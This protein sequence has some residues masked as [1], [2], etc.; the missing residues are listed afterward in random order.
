[1]AGAEGVVS[2]NGASPTNLDLPD[3]PGLERVVLND[4]P[5]DDQA[6]VM[7]LEPSERSRALAVYELGDRME[8]IRD[9]GLIASGK[10]RTKAEMARFRLA[11]HRVVEEHGP[12]TVRGAFYQMVARGLPKTESD[13]G[14]V[15]DEL[16]KM[17]RAERLPVVP[18]GWIVD[19]T[20]WQRKPQTYSSLDRMLRESIQT[21]RRAVWDDQDVYCEVWC[22]KDAL[23]G[24]LLPVTSEWD[25]PLMVSRG[26]SSVTFLYEAAEAIVAQDKPAF[27]YLFTDHDRSGRLIA[28][29][30]EE[31]LTGFAPG[32]EIHCVRA[33]V[34]EEQIEELDLPTRPA[35]RTGDPPAVELDAIRPADLR[36][37][38]R[39]C[40][41]R[42]VDPDALRRTQ[43]VEAEER[44]TLRRISR[45]AS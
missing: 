13:Y 44:E 25:V 41:E 20:R 14:R 38:V 31:D 37:I 29:K 10:R 24:V 1:M 36:S 39:D 4:L 28:D 12:L 23:A 5:A 27:I 2:T 11:L 30:I 17:R 21:Y 32:A 18:Y 9:A 42:H 34:T 8:E 26:F 3:L 43:A 15:Q 19:G 40:I 7:G 45:R 35:K 22:E 16:V 33:A 6:H